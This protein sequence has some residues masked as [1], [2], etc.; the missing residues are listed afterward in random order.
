M[1]SKSHD[2]NM[3]DFRKWAKNNNISFT[4]LNI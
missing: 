3:P 4:P 1:P 2:I